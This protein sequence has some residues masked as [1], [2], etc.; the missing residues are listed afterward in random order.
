[1]YSNEEFVYLCDQPITDFSD[2]DVASDIISLR[3]M[4]ALCAQFDLDIEGNKPMLIARFK[5]HRDAIL[6]ANQVEEM[7]AM[8][9]RDGT[10][11][12]DPIHAGLLART[13]ADERRSLDDLRDEFTSDLAILRQDLELFAHDQVQTFRS[14]ELP[15]II[16]SSINQQVQR[17][18]HQ[19][20]L[21]VVTAELTPV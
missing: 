17:I 6:A 2:G 8:A 10:T 11:D 9:L 18:Q 12:D 19:E 1:M 13:H 16:S 5:A 21:T 4:R 7:E 15:T 20:I 3:Q 14:Q